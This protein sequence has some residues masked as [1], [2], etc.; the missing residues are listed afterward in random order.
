MMLEL[1]KIFFSNVRGGICLKECCM[2]AS[3]SPQIFSIDF[4]EIFKASTYNN[5][6]RWLLFIIFVSWTLFS[7][8]TKKI[9]LKKNWIFVQ[10]Q[11]PELHYE[12]GVLSNYAKFTGKRLYQSLFLNKVADLRPTVLSKK[13]LWCRCFPVNFAK[14]LRAPFLQNTPGRWFCL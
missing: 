1:E 7:H 9:D 3:A 12:N 6:C 13:R 11:A 8:I 4:S 10:K 14:F 2:L 5:T